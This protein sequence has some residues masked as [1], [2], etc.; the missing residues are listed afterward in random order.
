MLIYN[1]QHGINAT[2][3][4]RSKG[5]KKTYKSA[6][7]PNKFPYSNISAVAT[8]S[9]KKPKVIRK[10]KTITQRNMQFLK[11]LGLKVKQ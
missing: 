3:P 11:G 6:R 8:G 5:F 10:K 2:T 7:K 4:I 1:N 9:K